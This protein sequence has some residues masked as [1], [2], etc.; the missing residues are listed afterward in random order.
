SADAHPISGSFTFR[1]GQGAEPS[2]SLV[3]SVLAREGGSA[4]VGGLHAAARFGLFGSLALLVGALVFLS[5]LWPAG[6]SEVLVRR[7]V[8]G[9]WAAA[10]VCTAAGLL[11]QGPYAGALPLG[12]APRPATIEA[13]LE[14]RFGRA[15]AARLVL[16]ALVLPLLAVGLAHCGR[17]LRT[18]GWRAAAV[19]AGVLLVASVTAAG[20]A[21]TGPAV[22]LAV[23]ADLVHVAAAGTWLGGLVL[24]VLALRRAAGAQVLVV[25]RGFSRLA[26]VA[27]VALAVSG[28]AQAWRQ[29]GGLAALSST[30]YGRLLVAK[31]VLV[32]LMV[33]AG[34]LNRASL[35]DRAAG[36]DGLRR[37]VG[38]GAGGEVALG[39]VVLVVTSLLV[40]SPPGREALD[41]P[42]SAN[43]AAAEH[44]LSVT[45]GPADLEGNEVHL[46]F[47][48]RA[49][50][51]G[52]LQVDEAGLHLASA[53]REVA[54]LE[55]PLQR[56]GP[57]HFV[58]YDVDFPFAGEW[59]LEVTAR[60]GEFT[61]ERFAATVDIS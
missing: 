14:G 29:L 24:L 50:G 13:V 28:S 43:V 51:G 3:E 11:L 21:T 33:A 2:R 41:R 39:M 48:A 5:L 49:P 52:V 8:W 15:W 16:L 32:G 30:T 56:A 19:A 40:N 45:V 59:E 18:A 54:A 58:A 46:I 20:H 34:A 42:F 1:V 6:A 22:G 10:L 7:L 23:A 31:V 17:R 57:G 26:A 61:R 55:V 60:F 36:G 53:E 27:V 4:A 37:R 47:T 12:E 38:R 44:D 35:G 25:A 9:A